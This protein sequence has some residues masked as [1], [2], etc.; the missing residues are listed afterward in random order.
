M[1]AT[2]ARDG[3]AKQ[4]RAV[5]KMVY[6][7]GTTFFTF[8][9]QPFTSEE[10]ISLSTAMKLKELLRSVVTDERGT[11]RRFQTL[12]YAVAGKSG[13]AQTG[14]TTP[15]GETLINKWFAGY[16]PA[17]SP[18]YALVVVDLESPSSQAVTNDVFDDL[19]KRIYEWDAQQQA[20]DAN[21][22]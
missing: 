19:V 21:P 17:Q 6:K 3:E 1:M 22:K 20:Q 2:I 18:K 9:E 11:G 8:P 15:Q 10:S 12:P 4:V 5:S 13:T 16:F 14:K 7:N